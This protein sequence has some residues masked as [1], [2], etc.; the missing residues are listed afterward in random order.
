MYSLVNKIWQKEGLYG[1]GKGFSACFY[2]AAACGF[3][4]FALYKFLKS[5]F[6]E[7]TFGSTV[8]MWIIY[9]SASLL[10][11]TFTLSVQYPYD[12]IKCRL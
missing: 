6:K 8:D 7:S 1:F 5:I 2:G 12:L 11:E 3:I 9:M 4:Y 10:A